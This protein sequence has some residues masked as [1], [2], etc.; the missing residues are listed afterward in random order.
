MLCVVK[1]DG[2]T[3]TFEI[4]H[5]RARVTLRCQFIRSEDVCR[6]KLHFLQKAGIEQPGLQF[7][8]QFWQ[9]LQP[10]N[11]GNKTS[12]CIVPIV[13][14]TFS[15]S[16]IVHLHLLRVHGPWRLRTKHILYKEP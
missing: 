6:A 13:S 9:A 11:P 7:A 15:V 8:D 5:S 1:I 2:I 3:W 12:M 10:T 14:K 16:A 4:S